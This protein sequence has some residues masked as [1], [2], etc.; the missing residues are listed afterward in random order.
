M[1]APLNACNPRGGPTNA[2]LNAY[3]PRGGPTNAPLNAPNP[4]G[5]PTNAPSKHN[6]YALVVLGKHNSQGLTTIK[7][8]NGCAWE[9]PQPGPDQYQSQQWSCFDFETLKPLC[10]KW[11]GALMLDC[12]TTVCFDFHQAMGNAWPWLL[13]QTEQYLVTPNCGLLQCVCLLVICCNHK[14][15]VFASMFRCDVVLATHKHVAN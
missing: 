13:C 8:S 10:L 9:A 15:C 14:M 4:R 5:G 3:N 6:G 1:N 11:V 2:P 7:A 12:K